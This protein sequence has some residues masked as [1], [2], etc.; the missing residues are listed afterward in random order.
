MSPNRTAVS[1]LFV[2]MAVG[3]FAAQLPPA[4]A[5]DREKPARRPAGFDEGDTAEE[6]RKMH[7]AKHTYARLAVSGMDDVPS[8]EEYLHGMGLMPTENFLVHARARVAELIAIRQREKDS[9]QAVRD[10]AQLRGNTSHRIYSDIAKGG[11]AA[12]AG[13]VAMRY[14]DSRNAS[15]YTESLSHVTSESMHSASL[16]HEASMESLRRETARA[17]LQARFIEAYRGVRRSGDV[18]APRGH[19]PHGVTEAGEST[20][21]LAAWQARVRLASRR[22]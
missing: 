10:R 16:A 2:A 11:G 8:F 21:E 19:I 4:N 7:A 20:D 22:Q 13:L 6:L 15:A 5:D 1:Q 3:A 17:V 14:A 9:H 12:R 18:I